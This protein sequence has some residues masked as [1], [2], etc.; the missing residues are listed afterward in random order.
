MAA[1][2][3]LGLAFA[4]LFFH[5]FR[6][7]HLHSWDKLQDWGHAYAVPVISGYLVWMRRAEL[8]RVAK[9]NFWPA[10]APLLLGVMCY[11]FFVV[12]VP[13]HM[14]QG[15][16]VVLTLGSVVLLVFGGGVLR[17]VV[18]PLLYLLFA[19]TISEQVMIKVTFKLQLIASQGAWLLMAI[20][21]R[22]LGYSV[23]VD[24]NTLTI[25]TRDGKSHPMNVAEACSGMRM[26][27]GF[28]AVAGWVALTQCKEWWKMIALLLLAAPVA[29]LMNVVRVAVLGW[30][31]IFVDPEFAKGE[32]HMLVGT[33]LL[34]VALFVFMGCLWALDRLFVEGE[35]KA[36]G[37]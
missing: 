20:A 13:N 12:G 7:Q 17:L 10:I 18:L 15:A 31:T 29:V 27:I 34:A 11:V 36:V 1:L 33:I 24:G 5:W 32:A 28:F 21:A 6:N 26:L 9:E 8:A 22:P 4:A 2:G 37:A 30:G 16:S 14:L 23:D 25:L 3:V 35:A 19:I